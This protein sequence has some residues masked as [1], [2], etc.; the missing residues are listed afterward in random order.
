VIAADPLDDA[1]LA[2]AA[3]D[4]G[5]ALTGAER[6]LAARPDRFEAALLRGRLLLRRGGA[7]ADADR[8]DDA[9]AAFTAADDAFTAAAAIA[10]SAL[11]AHL[12]RCRLGTARL[13][14]ALQQTDA[15][16]FDAD[17]FDAR[18]VALVADAD[19]ACQHARAIAPD[20]P[21][22]PLDVADL[23]LQHVRVRYLTGRRP[24]HAMYGAATTSAHIA[25]D[26]AVRVGASMADAW[27]RLG[28]LDLLHGNIVQH[29]S[30]DDPR[31]FF[32]RAYA[33]HTRALRLDGHPLSQLAQ[34]LVLSQRANY[35]ISRLLPI[36][37]QLHLGLQLARQAHRQLPG[38]TAAAA[39]IA[40]FHTKLA[41]DAFLRGA[42]F[43]DHTAEALRHLRPLAQQASEDANLAILLC[44]VYN[45]EAGHRFY[46]G[47]DP[48]AI[49]HESRAHIER[50]LAIHSDHPAMM[51]LR[52]DLFYY[53]LL[54]SDLRDRSLA[55]WLA[56]YDEA[57][58]QPSS[59]QLHGI[60]EHRVLRAGFV[61]RQALRDGD[62]PAA[63]ARHL[64]MQLRERYAHVQQHTVADFDVIEAHLW[65]TWL[66]LRQGERARAASHLANLADLFDDADDNHTM[67]T[68]WTNVQRGAWH[69]LRARLAAEAE[70][71][72]GVDAQRAEAR[73]ARARD[74]NP[75]VEPS[76]AF[77]RR[78]LAR[79]DASTD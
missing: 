76:I 50:F 72:A 56:D 17:A 8:L 20:H 43:G 23:H 22:P 49:L 68:A 19:A 11:D 7:M 55:T 75:Y 74:A 51:M 60:V 39:E 2:A 32:D 64:R 48:D 33:H 16:S 67:A 27:R 65:L 66:S 38:S 40:R 3:G 26:Q 1:Y 18:A 42:V 77:W 10:G 61:L 47:E 4:D 25:R 45:L 52:I 36:S 12:G 46:S 14:L 70:L 21:R 35:E 44:Q 79:L 31:P 30:Y 53:A 5:A 37:T 62:D 69:A 28:D 78:W 41:V 58:N 71:A 59:E 15:R 63:A 34:V 24:T 29:L 73:W 57:I 9:D 54:Y 13:A 6:V